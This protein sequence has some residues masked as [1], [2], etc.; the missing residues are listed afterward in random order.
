M[1]LLCTKYM[2]GLFDH[3]QLKIVNIMYVC[4]IAQVLLISSIWHFLHFHFTCQN[5]KQEFILKAA[6]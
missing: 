5:L 4:I 1:F 3:I 6:L 2:L